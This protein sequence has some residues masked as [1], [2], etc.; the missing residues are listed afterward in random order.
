MD[1]IVGSLLCSKVGFG[2]FQLYGSYFLASVLV[3]I[4]VS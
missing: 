1:D 3:R 2:R 4:Y